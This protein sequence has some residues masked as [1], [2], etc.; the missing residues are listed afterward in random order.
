MND[1]KVPPQ[2]IEV[3][4]S[5]IAS[6]LI[7]PET[8]EDIVDNLLPEHFY[9]TAHC[10]IFSTI[11]DQYKKKNPTDI[12]NISTALKESKQLDEIGGSVY[13][14]KFL[15]L[16]VAINIEYACEKIKE[17]A[18]LRKT[19]EICNKTII[20][21]FDNNNAKEIVDNI[22]RDIL[23]IDN[24]SIDNFITM[25]ELTPQSIDRY[26]DA[27][28]NNGD[29][30]IKTGF[31]EFD[32]L[33]GGLSG[34]KLI[35][36]AGRPRMGKTAIMLN[37][38]Q[39]MAQ[40]GD[41]VGIFEI[42]M[43]KEDLDDRIMASLTGI[44]TIK[45]QSGKYLGSTDWEKITKAATIKY[46]FPIIVDDTGGLKIPELKRRIR[47]MKKLGC[48]IIFIDQLSKI[49]GNR[50]KSKFEEATEIVEE[51]GHLKKE[52]RIPIVLLA[53]IS[54]Q[55][56]TRTGK[57]PMLEDLKNTGQLEEEGDIVIL[58]HRPYVY[59]KN[60]DDEDKVIFD[61]AKARGAPE[62]TINLCWSGKTTSFLNPPQEESEAWQT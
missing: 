15:D 32:T 49:V 44:N 39:Y 61:V 48:K 30:K 11:I 9:R 33:I 51:L 62:R 28:K 20:A 6:C 8:V 47:K 41:M 18:T 31:Y 37:M 3:E 13:L 35:I 5:I 1:L 21:C 10:K 53:Q 38:A 12:I 17:C 19:I 22:Q 54:R 23:N 25:K 14:A 26:E 55:A 27:S 58:L 46:D 43:D 7:F 16:P 52:L 50:K 36:I 60:P 56:I 42:E 57:R 45:L 24:F 34:S 4:E 59:T 29:Y 2:N 40:R